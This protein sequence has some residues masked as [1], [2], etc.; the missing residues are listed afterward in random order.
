MK[1]ITGYKTA[2]TRKKPSAPMQVLDKM[3]LIK[4]RALDYGCGKGF[5]AQHYNMDKFDPHWHPCSLLLMHYDTITCNYVLNVLPKSKVKDILFN[6]R[7][8]LKLGGIAYITV[9]RDIKKASKGKGCIQKPV[10]LDLPIVKEVKGQY[11]IY[12]YEKTLTT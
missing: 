4:G 5:D 9:R 2:I 3:S 8:Y 7:W 11:C 10:H 6:I 1:K 12:K